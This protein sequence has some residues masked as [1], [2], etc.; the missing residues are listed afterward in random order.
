ML[1]LPGRTEGLLPR[2]VCGG[3]SPLTSV[4]TPAVMEHSHG[5]GHH[6]LWVT[7]RHEIWPGSPQPGLHMGSWESSPLLNH[8]PRDL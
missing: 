8:V 6:S 3:G 1:S 4:V 5:S 7:Q 2:Y